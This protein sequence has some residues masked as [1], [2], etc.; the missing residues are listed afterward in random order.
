MK[1]KQIILAL[2]LTTGF[3]TQVHAE[4]V[5]DTITL[6]KVSK[7]KIE[8]CDT[9]QRIVINGKKHDHDFY[10][11]QRIAI[12]SPDDVRR[13]YK[14]V[15]SFGKITIKKKDGEDSKFSTSGNLDIGLCTMTSAPSDY[16]F[17][18]WPSFEVALSYLFNYHP[19]GE[20]NEWSIGFGIDW[21][22]YKM[23]NDY[24]F[25]KNSSG[26]LVPQA[27]APTMSDV[28][29]RLYTFS[30]QIP[31]LYTHHFGNSDGWGFT[32]GGIVNFNTGAHFNSD[33]SIDDYD[34]DI[35]T[36]KIGQRPVTIDIMGAVDIP[37]FANIYCK[38]SPMKYFKNGGPEMHQLSFG[39]RL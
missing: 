2:L 39:I 9:L 6:E 21:R 30:L 8:T 22:S 27:Y 10:Y 15:K 20:L 7:V 1:M 11:S 25:E 23:S 13:E 38:Y 32:L 29:T 5:G 18:L 31:I 3:A 36:N 14:G 4:T 16:S 24:Q 28:S 17:K 37:G 34:Y 12:K 35:D 33:Y 19:F 26:D